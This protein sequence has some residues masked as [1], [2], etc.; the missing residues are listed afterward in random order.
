[1][2]LMGLRLLVALPAA[3]SGTMTVAM[4]A[5]AL[6]G[7]LPPLPSALGGGPL[8]LLVSEWRNAHDFA[9]HELYFGSPGKLRGYNEVKLKLHKFKLTSS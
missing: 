9:L 7:A 4:L 2:A 1:M 5:A 6:D 8:Y 3:T